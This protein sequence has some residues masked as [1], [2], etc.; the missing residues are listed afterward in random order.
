[1][2]GKSIFRVRALS[3]LGFLLA[4]FLFL[5]ASSLVGQANPPL[6]TP[7]FKKITP[8]ENPQYESPMG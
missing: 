7:D 2:A 3:Q 5:A 8:S 1:M 4:V 6:A